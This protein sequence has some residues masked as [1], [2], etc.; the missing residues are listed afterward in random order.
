MNFKRELLE[1]K[2]YIILHFCKENASQNTRL[3]GRVTEILS[4]NQN[5][6]QRRNKL[7]GNSKV[8]ENDPLVSLRIS[9]LANRRKVCAPFGCRISL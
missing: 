8:Q 5:T 4:S 6:A 7:L 2:L 9:T 3:I 1:T